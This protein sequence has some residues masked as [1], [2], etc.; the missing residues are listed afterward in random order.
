MTVHKLLLLSKFTLINVLIVL[1]TSQCQL[2]ATLPAA[3]VRL[4][5]FFGEGTGRIFLDDVICNGT[6]SRLTDCRHPPIGQ[7]NCR[8]SEDAGVNCSGRHSMQL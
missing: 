4:E 2:F 7:H 8:H 5:A 1:R 6:E 3:D